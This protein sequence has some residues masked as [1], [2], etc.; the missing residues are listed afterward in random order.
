MKKLSLEMKVG[1]FS[2]FAIAALVYA[3][4][5]VSDRG[6]FS[7]GSYSVTV[8]VDSAEGLDRKTP[9]EIAGIQVGYVE[10][11]GLYEGNRAKIKLKLNHEV[12][13]GQDARAWVRTKGFLGETY[14]ELLPGN[15]AGGRIPEGGFIS[16]TNPY[17]DL[18]KVA[19]DVSEL[20]GAMKKMIVDEDGPFQRILRNSELLTQKLA[21]ITV[22]NQD[23]VN[24]MI[25]Q[26]REFSTDLHEVMAEK[27]ETIKDTMDR[28][29]SITKKVDEGKGTLGMLINDD[30]TA[31]NINDAARGISETVGGINR[32]Q[33]DFGYHLEYLVGT[34]DF[35][36]Y[37]G[38][39]LKPR[40]DKFFIFELVADPNPSPKE[41]ITNTTITTSGGSTTVTTDANVVK[42]NSL[43]ISAE[44]A[45]TFYN[46]TIR[47]GIIE[48]TGGLGLDWNQNG[49]AGLQFEAFDFQFDNGARPHLKIMGNLNVTK[50]FYVVSGLDDFISDQHPLDYFFGAG[51]K[52]VDNDFKSIMGAAS[53]H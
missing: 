9:V 36:N 28:L 40:P 51:L 15:S 33:I 21:E 13:L 48:S 22:Q 39:T 45:K 6:T 27:K 11:L 23:N 53:L 42:K 3:T 14:V 44:L 35:K 49:M 20:T 52:F 38:F 31:K 32:F 19:S 47:G 5:R 26:M 16:A 12:L 4:L 24:Q 30:E 1:L 7:G 41:T 43:L 25:L 18:G 37:V 46:F 8:I 29:D 2:A 34:Q 10:S 50:N 17:V